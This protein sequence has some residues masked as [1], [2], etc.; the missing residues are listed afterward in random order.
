[1]LLG[2]E[3]VLNARRAPAHLQCVMECRRKRAA[4]LTGIGRS[5]IRSAVK[6]CHRPRVVASSGDS[7]TLEQLSSVI[8]QIR[9]FIS[10]LGQAEKQIAQMKIESWPVVTMVEE[11]IGGARDLGEIDMRVMFGRRVVVTLSRRPSLLKDRQKP[12]GFI[13]RAVSRLQ[14]Q[15]GDSGLRELAIK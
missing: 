2:F 15:A 8:V 6:P 9:L 14:V 10:E 3:A 11:I 12:I 7:D 1:M 13:I 5:T 4:R